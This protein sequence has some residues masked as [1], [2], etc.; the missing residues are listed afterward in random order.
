MRQNFTVIVYRILLSVRAMLVS[1]EHIRGMDVT[2]FPGGGLEFGE[3]PRECLMREFRE[4][5]DIE[6]EVT[7]HFYTTD[8]FVA[9]AF[10]PN[11]QVISIYYLVESS[12][13]SEIKTG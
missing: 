8:F 6:V 1:D 11:V 2:K 13:A 12:A 10:D 7:S 5:L 4:E 3:G 9:S